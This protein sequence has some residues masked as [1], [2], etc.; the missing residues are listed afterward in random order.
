MSRLLIACACACA[1]AAAC[2]T[3]LGDRCAPNQPGPEALECREPFADA[4]AGV[5]DYPFKAFGDPCSRAEECAP[6]LTC[7]N[8]FTPGERWGT[9]VHRLPDSARCFADRDCASGTCVGRSGFAVDGT[10]AP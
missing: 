5:C 3:G 2:S 8:H 1:C 7:S 9:C 10:C 4:G 6:E